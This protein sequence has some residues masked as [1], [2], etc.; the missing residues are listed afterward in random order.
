MDA[1]NIVIKLDDV[2]TVVTAASTIIS[3]IFLC[4][5]VR[6]SNKQFR[7]IAEQTRLTGETV[8]I[9]KKTYLVANERLEKEKSAELAALYCKEILPRMTYIDIVFENIKVRELL[10]LKIPPTRMHVFDSDELN[11]LIS[12]SEQNEIEGLIEQMSYEDLYL[13]RRRMGTAGQ[14][15]QRVYKFKS[16]LDKE[17][18]KHIDLRSQ[19]VFDKVAKELNITLEELMARIELINYYHG[20]YISDF[21]HSVNDLLNTLEYFCMYFNTGVADSKVIYQSIHQTFLSTVQLMYFFIAKKNKDSIDKY[22]VN[23]ICLYNEWSKIHIDKQNEKMQ[24]EA[25][26]RRGRELMPQKIKKE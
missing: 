24:E 7:E 10:N 12:S 13:A 20:F 4:I 1:S 5:Q 16:I 6:H 9:N 21:N 22:Y 17:M 3:L 15:E 8:D 14:K 26:L 19:D 2:A 25:S 11:T 23:I 18:E